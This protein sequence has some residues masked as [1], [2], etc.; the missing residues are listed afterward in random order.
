MRKPKQRAVK[1]RRARPVARA[2]PADI[3]DDLRNQFAAAALNGITAG[4]GMFYITN[5]PV[6]D[7]GGEQVNSRHRVAAL[8]WEL[9]DLMFVYR[10]PAARQRLV[11]V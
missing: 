7:A 2:L 5:N 4:N 1:K 8:A 6:T 3:D 9:A 11:D 10:Y